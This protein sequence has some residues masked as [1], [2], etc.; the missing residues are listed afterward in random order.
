MRTTPPER[1]R[2]LPGVTDM[3][4][5]L[6]SFVVVVMVVLNNFFPDLVPTQFMIVALLFIFLVLFILPKGDKGDDRES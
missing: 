4:K 6:A 2:Y 1:S 5:G 3:L